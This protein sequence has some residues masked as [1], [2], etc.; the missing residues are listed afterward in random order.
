M[1]RAL[2]LLAL[3]ACACGPAEP[4][5]QGRAYYAASN[6]R[7]CH[8][9][10]AEGRSAGPDLSFV[11]F[12]QSPE[13][14]ERWL[15]GPKAWRP[16][17]TM[18]DPRLSP[19]ARREIVAYLSGLKG[20]DMKPRPWDAVADPV[21][22]GRLIFSR[23]G[24]V[25]CH[26]PGGRGGYPNSNVPGREIPAL[27][28]TA[29]TFT[30]PELVAKMRAGSRPLKEDPSG[31]EPLVRMPAWGEVFSDAELEALADYLL[32]LAPEGPAAVEEW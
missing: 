32:T 22:K 10:G 30:K 1:R 28:K 19:T 23:A 24:C 18:P 9:I 16:G 31:P 27:S 13:W 29:R 17:T 11:G 8:R 21:A 7:S 20:Q 5:S 12:R 6:C 26:G 3:L 4:V 15:S 25:A 2:F 14:L